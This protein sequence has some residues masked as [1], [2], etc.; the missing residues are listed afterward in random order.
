[1][2]VARGDAQPGLGHLGGLTSQ[3]TGQRRSAAQ[4]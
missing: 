4:R 1:V 3:R 2:T